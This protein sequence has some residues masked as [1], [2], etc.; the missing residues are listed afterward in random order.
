MIPTD[1][2]ARV[3]VVEADG[4]NVLLISSLVLGAPRLV[5][6]V[7]KEANAMPGVIVN[8]LCRIWIAS[9]ANRAENKLSKT[10]LLN[11][12]GC[13]C[14]VPNTGLYKAMVVW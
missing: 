13:S 9:C 1:G 11:A 4:V 5:I 8:M 2:S 12:C 7:P 6:V 3:N 10:S 14:D